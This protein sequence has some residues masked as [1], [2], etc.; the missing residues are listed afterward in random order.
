MN[1]FG[2]FTLNVEYLS[3]RENHKDAPLYRATLVG[4]AQNE[5]TVKGY[6]DPIY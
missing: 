3:D 4:Y 6:Y 1:E 5:D 2:N